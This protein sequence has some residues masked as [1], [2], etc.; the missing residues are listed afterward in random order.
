MWPGLLDSPRAQAHHALLLALPSPS[1]P[2]FFEQIP[3]AIRSTFLDVG[4]EWNGFYGVETNSLLRLWAAAGP[5]VCAEIPKVGGLFESGMCW[6]TVLLGTPLVADPVSKWP[7]YVSC[8]GESGIKTQAGMTCPIFDK[9]RNCTAVWDLDS[10]M[11]LHAEDCQFL[12]LLFQSLNHFH[13]EALNLEGRL[14][15]QAS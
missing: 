2:G 5:I 1:S 15:S 12:V 8:D 10:T 4:W 9:V 3:Q 6:D 14:P 13:P 11:P 7:G